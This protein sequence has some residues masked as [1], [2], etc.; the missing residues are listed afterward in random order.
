MQIYAEPVGYGMSGD[1]HHITSQMV[2]VVLGQCGLKM[3][4]LILKMLIV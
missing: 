3:S 2:M 1:A 4:M